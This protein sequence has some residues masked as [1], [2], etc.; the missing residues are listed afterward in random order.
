MQSWTRFGFSASHLGSQQVNLDRCKP[1]TG[2]NKTATDALKANKCL[3]QTLL[4]L[5]TRNMATNIYPKNWPVAYAQACCLVCC[6]TK[7]LA[8]ETQNDEIFQEVHKQCNVTAM[9]LVQTPLRSEAGTNTRP[10]IED[11][12]T[13]RA[14]DDKS[15]TTLCLHGIMMA[16][17]VVLGLAKLQ[18]VDKEVL[19]DMVTMD[20]SINKRTSIKIDTG[21]SR[22]KVAG[23]R[24]VLREA[25]DK[26]MYDP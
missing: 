13:Q 5:G 12:T 21:I 25:R 3:L 16:R 2:K 23:L 1:N 26:Q 11:A 4:H 22:I 7:A 6:T 10:N 18:V 8:K 19:Q 15:N 9:Y 17:E 14:F 24:K 20:V